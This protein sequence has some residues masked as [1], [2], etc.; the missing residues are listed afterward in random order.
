[1]RVITFYH[2]QSTQPKPVRAQS[3]RLLGSVV[4]FL[5]NLKWS[6][7]RNHEFAP[8]GPAQTTYACCHTVMLYVGPQGMAYLHS[9]DIRSHGNLKSSNCVVDSRFVLKLTDFGLPSL[10]GHDDLHADEDTY[11][12]YRGTYDTSEN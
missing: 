8:R 12:Y 10:R 11:V 9:S 2:G 5:S 3:M 7:D 6:I 4:T 1:M